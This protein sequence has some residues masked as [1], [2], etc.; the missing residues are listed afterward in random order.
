MKSAKRKTIGIVVISALALSI[1]GAIAVV[2]L[3]SGEGKASPPDSSGP[4]D[5]L[6]DMPSTHDPLGPDP[7]D[8]D[9]AASGDGESSVLGVNDYVQANAKN[10]CMMGLDYSPYDVGLYRN[11][12]VVGNLWGK[13]TNSSPYVDS[14]LDIYYD[15]SEGDC[16]WGTSLGSQ[17]NDYGLEVYFD[18]AI[19]MDTSSSYQGHY[20]I[21]FFLYECSNGCTS[22]CSQLGTFADWARTGGG[23]ADRTFRNS[24]PVDPDYCD[25]DFDYDSLCIPRIR[26][27]NMTSRLGT[28]YYRVISYMYTCTTASCTTYSYDSDEGCF[29]VTWV[30]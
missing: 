13:V 23:V 27:D 15:D 8:S 29:A 20:K 18:P 19:V 21:Y 16:G 14:Y 1:A 7:H 3:G 30:D 11:R 5:L 22:G 24:V 4:I 17:D 25:Q 2:S 26:I 10:V 6:P 9:E 28:K 12:V